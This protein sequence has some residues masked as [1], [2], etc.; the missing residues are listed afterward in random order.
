MYIYFFIYARQ[1]QLDK[2]KNKQSQKTT[3]DF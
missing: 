3:G 2:I 1:L